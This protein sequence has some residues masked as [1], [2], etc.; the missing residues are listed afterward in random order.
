MCACRC[1]YR[2]LLARLAGGRRLLGRL[3]GGRRRYHGGHRAPAPDPVA[4]LFRLCRLMMPVLPVG[5]PLQGIG[6]V[7][8]DALV[9]RRAAVQN[10]VSRTGRAQGHRCGT[11][12]G[13]RGAYYSHNGRFMLTTSRR[14]NIGP[15]SGSNG[16]T[17]PS[18]SPSMVQPATSSTLISTRPLER[19]T[20]STCHRNNLSP[21]QLGC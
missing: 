11:N 12:G 7:A 19:H 10:A 13:R 17:L 2:R 8:A 16:P 4:H 18:T 5:V 20:I 21:K 14:I 15:D 1:A 3:A 6:D 9:P